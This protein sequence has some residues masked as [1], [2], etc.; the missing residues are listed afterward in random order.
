[1]GGHW[2]DHEKDYINILE[3]KVVLFGLKALLHDVRYKQVM[4]VT[5]YWGFSNCTWPIL[6]HGGC[7]FPGSGKV[8]L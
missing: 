2:A 3:L 6:V 8:I 5:F 7:C 1:M 4:V